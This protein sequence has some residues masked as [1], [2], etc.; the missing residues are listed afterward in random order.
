M[1]KKIAIALPRSDTGNALTTIASAAGNMIA[2]PAPWSTRKKIIQASARSPVGVAP[3]SADE[4][5]NSAPWY[6]LGRLAA[7][8]GRHAAEG[9]AALRHYLTLP[10]V[11]GQPELQH[12]WW[13]LAQL[14]A[15]SG[16]VAAARAS[17]QQ[18]LKLDPELAEARADLAKL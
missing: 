12:A 11:R 9:A 2:A 5:A 17:L 8:S 10:V 15:R 7:L 3:Q 18:A 4:P 14:Q 16:D 6:Q 1:P 13:R